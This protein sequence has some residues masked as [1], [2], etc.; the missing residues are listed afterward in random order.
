[1]S[2]QIIEHA[3]PIG[4]RWS[5]GSV[6]FV[7]ADGAVGFGDAEFRSRMTGLAATYNDAH[8]RYQADHAADA[9]REAAWSGLV[10]GA[11]RT[12]FDAA[13]AEDRAAQVA[14][15]GHLTPARPVSPEFARDVWAT[16]RAT[17]RAGQGY[18]IASAD[19]DELTALHQFGNRVPHEPQLWDEVVRRYRIENRLIAQ[20]ELA[21]HP[22]TPNLD[23]PLPTGPDWAAARA[24]VEGWEAA[25]A[26]RLER[27]QA[28]KATAGD[29]VQFLAVA[30]EVPPQEVLDGIT[31]A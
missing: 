11:A 17:D 6:G 9:V 10:R 3:T 5:I 29:L 15:A 22:V 24:A 31:G 4:P 16:H 19:L 14:D 21:R 1:M 27:V 2:K 25:H 28:N 12:A 30:F 7:S 8:A 26:A 18:R 23:D 13:L 20:N